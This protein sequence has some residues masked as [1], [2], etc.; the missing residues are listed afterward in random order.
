MGYQVG[1]GEEYP[2][3]TRR[4]PMDTKVWNGPEFEALRLAKSLSDRFPFQFT[5]YGTADPMD[6]VVCV[7]LLTSSDIT[8]WE[9]HSPK[10]LHWLGMYE[11]SGGIATDEVPR[12]G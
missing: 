2:M 6:Y 9:G 3:M 12:G 7:E 8:A 1:N 5:A 11:L 4:N 10:V